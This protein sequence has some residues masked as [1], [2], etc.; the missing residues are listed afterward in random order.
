MGLRDASKERMGSLAAIC[1]KLAE[2]KSLWSAACPDPAASL[3]TRAL[4]GLGL[5]MD[6]EVAIKD[7]VD[8][9][10]VSEDFLTHRDGVLAKLSTVISFVM[11]SI[12]Q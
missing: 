8:M 4:R 6:A 9:Q 7:V 5:L 1:P 2:L 11:S 3:R 12:E 10:N